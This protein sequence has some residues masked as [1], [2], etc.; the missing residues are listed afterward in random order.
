MKFECVINICFKM[1]GFENPSSSKLQISIKCD[2]T[3]NTVMREKSVSITYFSFIHN[4]NYII[5]WLI[6]VSFF[7]FFKRS[8]T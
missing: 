8:L 1:N 6:M 5:T 3:L 2:L 7:I 4:D